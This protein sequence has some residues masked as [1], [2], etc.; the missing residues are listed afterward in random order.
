MELAPE[1]SASYEHKSLFVALNATLCTMHSFGEN[2]EEQ[3]RCIPG[4]TVQSKGPRSEDSS[5]PRYL[6]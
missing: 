5:W 2:K 6:R 3:N 1:L 4:T